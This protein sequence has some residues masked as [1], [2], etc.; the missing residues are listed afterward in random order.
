[1]LV[2][3]DVV[4]FSAAEVAGMLGGS[5]VLVEAALRRARTALEPRL[6]ADR[7]PAPMPQS[8]RERE[9]LTR[10][11]HAFEG[12]DADGIAAL[13]STDAVLWIAPH[14]I[15]YAGPE[16]IGAFLTDRF[17]AHAGRRAR[18][19]WTRANG[20]P[21]FGHYIEDA[22]APTFRSAGVIVLMLAGERIA[23][24]TRFGDPAIPPLFG[25]PPTLPG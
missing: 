12:A 11:T 19:V 21:A 22:E 9:L 20:Q 13:L 10:F 18:C 25:F 23:R 24:I 5:E 7:E 4:G 3:R 16:A 17:A 2:L 6:A 14:P 15:E 8:A 1:V